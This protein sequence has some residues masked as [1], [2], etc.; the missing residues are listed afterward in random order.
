MDNVYNGDE[1]NTSL[2]LGSQAA[3]DVFFKTNV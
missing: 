1:N 3:N 2:Y